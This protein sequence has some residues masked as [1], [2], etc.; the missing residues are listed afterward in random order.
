MK[1]FIHWL[2]GVVKGWWKRGQTLPKSSET[3]QK[4]DLTVIG[5]N[6]LIVIKADDGEIN[7]SQF[8]CTKR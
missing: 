3:K 1:Q 8:D 6:N 2:I 4:I 7:Q 5:D